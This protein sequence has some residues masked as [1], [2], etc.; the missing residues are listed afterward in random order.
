MIYKCNLKNRFF[1]EFGADI[2]YLRFLAV[3]LL[4]PQPPIILS[5]LDFI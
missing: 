4:R 5:T 3:K 1:D 2:S